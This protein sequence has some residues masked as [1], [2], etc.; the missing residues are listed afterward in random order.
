MG[1]VGEGEARHRRPPTGAKISGR[2][3]EIGSPDNV[4]LAAIASRGEAQVD[5]IVVRDG[6]PFSGA[7]VVLVPQ[8]PVN[9][10]PLFRRDQSDSDGTFTLSKVVPGQYTVIALANGWDLEWANPTV[11]HPYLKGGETVQVPPDGRLNV[12]VNLQ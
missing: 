5:G 10:A 7:M 6:E 8:D 2:A 11:L 12:K 4:H 3:I 1:G 9:N